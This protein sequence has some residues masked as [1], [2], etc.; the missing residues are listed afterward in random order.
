MR[1]MIVALDFGRFCG[2]CAGSAGKRSENQDGL[3]GGKQV[4]SGSEGKC[5][6]GKS[7]YAGKTASKTAK[8]KN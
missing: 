3:R 5:V 8:K 6:A 1:S 2:M 7:K 4:W